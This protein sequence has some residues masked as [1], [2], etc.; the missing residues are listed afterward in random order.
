MFWLGFSLV[1][2]SICIVLVIWVWRH[3]SDPSS[4]SGWLNPNIKFNLPAKLV[5]SVMQTPGLQ[6]RIVFNGQEFSSP[7]DMPPEIRKAYDQ[8]MSG[9]LADADRDGIPDIME[10]GHAGVFADVRT[11]A[12]E[13]P[14]E[15][16]RK[17][18]EMRDGGLI[19]DQEYETKRAEIISRM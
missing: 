18:N 4:S 7:N 6:S 9:V 13:D 8:V 2:F 14:A 15:T 16:L 17:L 3:K 12:R 11:L 5:S 1:M 10:G 19:T